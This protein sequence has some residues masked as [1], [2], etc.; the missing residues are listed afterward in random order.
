MMN[1]D[2]LLL[3][4]CLIFQFLERVDIFL[5]SFIERFLQMIQ[6][7]NIVLP[8]VKGLFVGLFNSFSTS[9]GQYL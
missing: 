8:T 1:L 4:Q 6:T 9:V 3:T 5:L 7:R 2:R